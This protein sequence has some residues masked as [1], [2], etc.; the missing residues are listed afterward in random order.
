MNISI[1]HFASKIAAALLASGMLINTAAMA[2]GTTPVYKL[3]VIV[4]ES[5]ATKGWTEEYWPE[6]IELPDIENSISVYNSKQGALWINPSQKSLAG[7]AV[8]LNKKGYR[9]LFH[10]AWTQ[11]GYPDRKVKR[12][13]LESAN[14]YGSS[15]LGT[16]RFYKT[17]FAHVEFDLQLEKAIPQ[18]V[19]QSFIENQKISA[20][21][22]PD[23]WRFNLQESRKIRPGELHYLDHPLFGVL[24]QISKIEKS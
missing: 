7:K 3:E 9:V 21:N 2:E 10:E 4:F 16:L 1:K 5:L 23:Q 8:A 18:R 11:F 24:V 19:K 13:L 6:D 20:N 15:V 12:V 17:R 22:L 14:P